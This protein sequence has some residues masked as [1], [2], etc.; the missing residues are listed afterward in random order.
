MAST[1]RRRTPLALIIAALSIFFAAFPL[2]AAAVLIWY[3]DV[4][5]RKPLWVAFVAL[6][7]GA[8]GATLWSIIGS[9]IAISIVGLFLDAQTVEI[10]ATVVFAPI[11]EEFFK[12]IILLILLGLPRLY[13]SSTNG[14]VYG[15]MTGLGFAITENFLYYIGAYFEAGVASWVSTIIVRTVFTTFVHVMASGMLGAALGLA[16]SRGHR[17]LEMLALLCLGYAGGVVIHLVWNLSATLAEYTNPVFF[18]FGIFCFFLFLCIILAMGLL[19]LW[20]DRSILQKEFEEECRYG[21]L[22]EG[23]SFVL[24]NASR[25]NALKY[26]F[27]GKLKDEYQKTTIRLAVVK[28][29]YRYRPTQARHMEVESLRHA[30]AELQQRSLYFPQN[31]QNRTPEQVYGTP[32]LFNT[33]ASEN[34]PPPPT[35]PAGPHT[36]TALNPAEFRSRVR[37]ERNLERSL[38]ASQERGEQPQTDAQS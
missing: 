19:S 7:W 36:I 29:Q 5:N 3:A 35:E 9:G 11:V 15:A 14:L 17:P 30:I 25:R 20:H 12:G 26:L 32:L 22:S 37:K 8:L 28:H 2:L 1:Q 31:P 33:G 16:A 18:L 10:I 38:S 4:Y 27:P 23:D 24:T 21:V 6:V 34:T 13:E